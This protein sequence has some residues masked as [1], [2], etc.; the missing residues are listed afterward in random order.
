MTT[1]DANMTMADVKRDL[2]AVP[3]LCG[4]RV[5]WARLSGRLNQFATVSVTHVEHGEGYLRGPAWRDWTFSWD[6]VHRA[7]TTGKPL[8][9]N[10]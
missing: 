6:A 1:M 4:K 2:P 9:G 8:N 5:L 3:I 7:V 10:V